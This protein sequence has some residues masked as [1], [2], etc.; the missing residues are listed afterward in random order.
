[1]SAR[2]VLVLLAVLLSCTSAA[3]GTQVAGRFRPVEI[4]ID[5]GTTPLAAYQVEVQADGA[6]IV[7]VEGGAPAAFSQP[8]HYDPAALRGHRIIL[9]AFSTGDDLP[10]GRVRVATLHM[11]E[12]AGAEPTYRI[13]LMAAAGA[14]GAPLTPTVE[15]APSQG[16]PA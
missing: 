6:D 3:S 12:A 8:P 15:I 16:D 4:W 9:A 2:R 11:R 1:M 14:D 13:E 7:G 10:R 5:S